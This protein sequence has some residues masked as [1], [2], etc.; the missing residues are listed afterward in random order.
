[1]TESDEDRRFREMVQKRAFEGL[2]D[3]TLLDALFRHDR[4]DELELSLKEFATKELESLT[5]ALSR[6]FE[7]GK[8]AIVHG[9]PRRS[10]ALDSAL[11]ASWARP[12]QNHLVFLD[13]ETVG[14][15]GPDL[16][17]VIEVPWVDPPPPAR[18]PPELRYKQILA[19]VAVA[20]MKR[21]P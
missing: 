18:P 20:K 12:P 13:T 4:E 17:N 3:V 5:A 11:Y 2:Q 8:L 6:G 16:L 10:F 1:M 14:P 7:P 9:Y 19:I 21:K 15:P